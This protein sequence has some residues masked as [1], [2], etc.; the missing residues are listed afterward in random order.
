MTTD[1]QSVWRARGARLV[2]RLSADLADEDW[3]DA[4]ALLAEIGEVA[5]CPLAARAAMRARGAGGDALFGQ[6]VRRAALSEL[7]AALGDQNK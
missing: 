3:R 1:V 4:M 6:A 7:S 5:C 2:D